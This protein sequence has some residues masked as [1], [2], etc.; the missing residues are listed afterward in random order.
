MVVTTHIVSEMELGEGKIR[1]ETVRKRKRLILFHAGNHLDPTLTN[2]CQAVRQ[3]SFTNQSDHHLDSVHTQRQHNTDNHKHNLQE[4]QGS[5]SNRQPTTTFVV[6]DT[7][8]VVDGVEKSKR[9]E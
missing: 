5:R 3:P 2:D 4:R 8:T 7:F 1:N 9:R 6:F